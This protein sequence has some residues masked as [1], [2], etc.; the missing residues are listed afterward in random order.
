MPQIKRLLFYDKRKVVLFEMKQ[1]MSMK[2]LV[3]ITSGVILIAATVFLLYP[4]SP[5]TEAGM[6]YEDSPSSENQPTKGESD[7]PVTITEFG[8]YKCPSCKAWDEDILPRLEQEFIDEGEAQLVFINTPFH[9]EE[10]ELAALA[11]ESI[12]EHEPE[13]F[14]SFHEALFQ[15]QPDIQSH[16]DPWVTE[17]KLVEVARENE[18]SIDEER[19][20]RDINQQTFMD[21]LQEDVVLVED[22]EVEV[23]PTV[24]VGNIKVEDP[25]DYESIQEL[26][27]QQREQD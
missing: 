2:M 22:Y 27:E 1:L 5:S 4:S 10:S 18:V 14:W 12:W 11:G 21:R 26:V 8:D 16:D 15:Q 24:M 9:G 13:A 6:S 7:A 19:L 17:D 23:T 3:L 20:A 25:F